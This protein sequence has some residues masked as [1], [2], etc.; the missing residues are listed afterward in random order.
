[1][2][3]E[4]IITNEETNC[5]LAE[6]TAADTTPAATQANTDASNIVSFTLAKHL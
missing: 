5:P 4:P 6:D 3:E 1:M 2:L